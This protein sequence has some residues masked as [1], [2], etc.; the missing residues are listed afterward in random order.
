MEAFGYSE[1]SADF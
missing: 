1:N